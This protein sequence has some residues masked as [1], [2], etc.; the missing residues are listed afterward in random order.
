MK[1]SNV[2]TRILPALA[3]LAVVTGAISPALAQTNLLQDGG[4][5]GM[6]MN[7][8]DATWLTL[9]PGTANSDLPYWTTSTTN[10]WTQLN[11]G[12]QNSS[13]GYFPAAE[14]GS[15]YLNLVSHTYYD[16]ANTASV[17]QSFAVTGGAQ[18]LVSYYGA[19]REVSNK[20]RATMTFDTAGGGVYD[21]AELA[22]YSGGTP[23]DPWTLQSFTF[24][25]PVGA[26]L[27]TLEFHAVTPTD[28]GY[29]VYLDDV[30]VTATSGNSS[31][32]TAWAHTHA[33]DQSPSEDYN[34]DGVSNGVAFFMGKDGLATNPGVENGKVTWPHVGVVTSY[35]VQV[36]TDL[37]IWTDAD[38]G[39][40]DEVS[41][42][43][44][45]IYTFPKGIGIP[46]KK[47]CRLQVTP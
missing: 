25:A 30:L 32:Y 31:E 3:A 4:F 37:G 44:F 41:S 10:G 5:E 40:V 39:D 28:W 20:V 47:F 6:T 16:N 12:I 11:W 15:H 26:T 22:A 7:Q 19:A 27:A 38:P 46:E 34:N 21:S 35:K 9:G 36:S 23:S 18:Y 45:V 43:G 17:S 13:N 33:G 29:G 24:T 8:P 2:F 1:Q 14:E 42:P